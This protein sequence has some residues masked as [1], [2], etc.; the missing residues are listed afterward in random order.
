VSYV[1]EFRV[2]YVH[3]LTVAELARMAK[4]APGVLDV[5]EAVRARGRLTIIPMR[6]W[7]RAMRWPE[8]GL[9]WIPTSPAIQDFAAVQGYAMSGL[10]TYFDPRSNFDIGFRH[11]IGTA[12]PFRGISHKTLK[13]DVIE[14]EL[15]S[16]DLG[17]IQFRRVS[18][19]DRNGKPAVGL[20]VEIN[21]YDEWHPTELSFYLMRMACKLE[22]K[23]P[24]L[25]APGRDFS[26]FLRHMGSEE[27]FHLLQ[28]DGARADVPAFLADWRKRV[29]IYQ[30]LSKRFWLY[31]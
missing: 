13:I 7:R 15:R 28:R 26:G 24:F 22:A 25:P 9:P 12:Y 18:G 11:G 17:G 21:D 10:G 5:T 3:G 23:N 19:V 27:F 31:Q 30:N 1:G 8:T 2:P 20:Y 14:K 16:L 4:E 29:L 6:G